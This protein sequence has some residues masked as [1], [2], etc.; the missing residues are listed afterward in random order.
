MARSIWKGS[1]SFGLVQIPIYLYS[2]E[3]RSEEI[4]FSLVDRRDLAPIGYQKI[5]KTTGEPVPSEEI[6]RGVEH[7]A[8]FVTLSPEELEGASPEVTHSAEIVDFVEYDQIPPI[9]FDKPYYSAPQKNGRKAYALLREAL[10]RSGKLGV[11]RV[12][13]RTRQYLAAVYPRG[14]AI[15]LNLL[16]FHQEL[17]APEELDL[18]GADLSQLGVTARELEV[19]D[20]LIESM[21]DEWHP[22]TYRDEY[23]DQLIALIEEKARSGKLPQRGAASPEAAGEVVDL[24]GL[25]KESVERGKPQKSAPT[26][27]R[28][29]RRGR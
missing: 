2:A 24:M 17:A 16:R 3:R 25:L 29:S 23:H 7:E 9:Y 18:P 12:V 22:E 21:A 19:A 20:R 1:I 27:R 28:A 15:V 4:H 6:V 5:N 8:G 26:P 10:K 13:I 11:A 14:D